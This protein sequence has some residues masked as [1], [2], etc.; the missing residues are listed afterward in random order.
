M[1]SELLTLVLTDSQDS[2][3]ICNERELISGLQFK[4]KST[5]WSIECSQEIC[6]SSSYSR[7][8]CLCL[9]GD[10]SFERIRAFP[11]IAIAGEIFI[12]FY[13][14]LSYFMSPLGSGK[15]LHNSFALIIVNSSVT[16]IMH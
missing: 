2:H 10:I 9:S 5:L 14:Q 6:S 12:D 11:F 8:A 15:S 13:F 16:N 1:N 7:M 4:K 3:E